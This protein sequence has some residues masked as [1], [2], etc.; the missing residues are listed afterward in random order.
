MALLTNTGTEPAV[1]ALGTTRRSRTPGPQSGVPRATATISWPQTLGS[2]RESV[3]GPAAAG[4][5]EAIGL[6]E[7]AWE[8]VPSGGSGRSSGEV[9]PPPTSI[10]QRFFVAAASDFETSIR[11]EHC[12]ASVAEDGM[13]D[14]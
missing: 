14:D 13:L 4:V 11:R 10:D 7:P 12:N 3:D 6:V 9:V 8:A 1:V 5:T 2:G